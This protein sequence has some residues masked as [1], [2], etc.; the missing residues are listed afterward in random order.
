MTTLFHSP[1]SRSSAVAALVRELDADIE[2]RTVSIPRIDGTGGVDPANPHPEGKVPYLVDGTEEVRERGAIM[3][4]LTDRFPEAGLGPVVGEA[5]RGAYLSW[6]SYYQGV[7]EPVILLDYTGYQHPA[8]HSAIR[9]FD[10][11]IDTLTRALEP[12]PWLLGERFSAADLLCSSP[13]LWFPDMIKDRPVI[14]D[15][16]ARCTARP[17]VQATMAAD[18]AALAA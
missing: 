13:F 5:G 4:Y 9:D 7:I 16:V 6:L 1:K 11:M 18:E 12:G 15:W 17:G 8:V 3:A 2:I 14:A 10:T